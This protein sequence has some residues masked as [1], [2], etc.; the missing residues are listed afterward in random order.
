MTDKSG[1]K[2]ITFVLSENKDGTLSI[3]LTFDPIY[4]NVDESKNSK[5]V[6]QAAN[7]MLEAVAQAAEPGSLKVKDGER[8]NGK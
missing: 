8:K 2:T 7:M 1:C 5:I 3:D 6:C 4:N